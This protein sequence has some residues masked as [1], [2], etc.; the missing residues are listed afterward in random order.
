MFFHFHLLVSIF[1]IEEK[2]DIEGLFLFR[3]NTHSRAFCP[4]TCL[5]NRDSIVHPHLASELGQF[6]FRQLL[7]C[8]PAPFMVDH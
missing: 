4:E 8:L 6:L 1:L 3:G 7:L 5:Q 2:G